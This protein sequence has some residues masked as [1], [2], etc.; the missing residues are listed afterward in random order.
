MALPSSPPSHASP[1][2]AA[3]AGESPPVVVPLVAETASVGTEPTP[4][5]AVRVRVEV[6]HAS[7]RVG[8]DLASEEYRPTV[9]PIGA[10]ASA[11]VD[12]YRDGDDIVIPVYE[13]RVVV[14]RKLFLKEEVRLTRVRQV[15]HR[16]GDVAVRSERAVFERQQPDGSWREVPVDPGARVAEA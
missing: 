12:P 6:E 7:E 2:A 3:D 14:E 15:E 1:G 4:I 10:P 11:R 5:G 8:V 16:E 13:E 9:R